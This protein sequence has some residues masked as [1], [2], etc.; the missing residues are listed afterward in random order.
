MLPKATKN[1]GTDTLVSGFSVQPGK[2]PYTPCPSGGM[3]DTAGV[4]TA[5]SPPPAM[6]ESAETSVK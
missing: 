5:G 1:Q 6:S 3:P 2:V 4:P